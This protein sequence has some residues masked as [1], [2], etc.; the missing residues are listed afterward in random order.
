RHLQSATVGQQHLA[1]FAPGHAAR[2]AELVLERYAATHP[3]V[4]ASVRFVTPGGKRGPAEASGPPP[5][6]ELV[7]PATRDPDALALLT[8]GRGGMAR[9]LADLGRVRSKYDCLLA[10]NL[11]PEVPVDRHVFVK[12]LR[13]WVNAD[14]FITPLDGQSLVEFEPGPPARWRFV[15]S[16]GDTRAVEIHLWAD[17]LADRNATVLRFQ[18][19]AAPLPFGHPLPPEARVSLT[20]RFDLEDRNFHTETHRN[21]GAEHHFTAHCR[22]LTGAIGFEFTPAENRRVRVTSDRGQ[23]HHESEWSLGV[24]HPVE[25]TRGQAASGDAYSPGW[26]DVPLGPGESTTVLATAEANPVPE[27]ETDRFIETRR[28]SVEAAVQ[29]AR[30]PADD[31]LGR[32][33]AAAIPA[34]VVRRNDGRTVIA[35]YPWFLDWGRDSLICA[36]GLLAA[37][38]VGEVRELLRVFGRF[39]EGGTL[40]NVIH[41]EDASNR[42]TSDAPLWY[43]VVCQELA[44]L[45]VTV[46]ES[47]DTVYELPVDREGRT[48]RDVLISI[49]RGYIR[50]TPNGIRMDADS[51]L[52]WSP[53]HFTWMDTNYPAGTPREGYPVEIQVL[54]I[55]LLRQL[56][57]IDARTPAEDWPALAARAEHSLHTLYWDEQ[58]GYLADL[59]IAEPGQPAAQAVVDTALRSNNL[60]AVSLGLVSGERARRCVNAALQ[61]LVVPG[62]LRSLAPLPVSP[63]LPIRG[64]D[65]RLLNNPVEPYWPRYEGDEDT[66]RKPAYHNGTAWTWT[67]PT[68][69]EALARAWD[70]DPAAVAAAR[71]YLA[72][73]GDL[74]DAGCLGQLPEILDGDAPHTQRGCDAQAWS[75]TE[76]L[77]VW[78]L[79]APA[80]SPAHGMGR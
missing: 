79:L 25:A 37:G 18:R 59:L 9:L 62:A 55:R 78:K 74:L 73:V 49:A 40:P 7:P 22:P 29:A 77:R 47:A 4:R 26:F 58:R 52:V 20:L 42:N 38:M 14:G 41:G 53:S 46:G 13:A 69:C 16:A 76:A 43:G 33:L 63:P 70:F 34:F 30:L 68:F 61:H 10:A 65:G 15:A 36:R 21:G 35:G 75:V 6:P 64:A 1:C 23:Y 60:F 44:A 17:L 8:N 66:R 11:H 2:D 12:R 19:A 48:L 27:A 32:R 50:G 72:S 45:G 24:A 51:A 3:S 71:A 54:W 80:E 56:A 28:R 67:F 57:R 39:E 5:D 31:E